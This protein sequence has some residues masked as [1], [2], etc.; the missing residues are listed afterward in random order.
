MGDS[1]MFLLLLSI[2]TSVVRNNN[3]I[4]LDP[5]LGLPVTSNCCEFA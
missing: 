3:K 1:R 5:P 4:K 2:I